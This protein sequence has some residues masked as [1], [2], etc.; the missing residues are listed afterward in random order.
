M[1]NSRYLPASRR[2]CVLVVAC[3]CWSFVF[4][5]PTSLAMQTRTLN[6]GYTRTLTEEE[7]AHIKG[8]AAIRQDPGDGGGGVGGNAAASPGPGY[9]W[10]G[11][12]GDVST[13][14]GNKL[15]A[16]PTV[17]WTARGGMT[18]DLTLYHN[19]ETPF[20]GSR[21]A[22]WSLIYD[23]NISADTS[24]NV[25]VAWG[26][27][28][29]YTFGKNVD[30]SYSPPPGIH[31]RL[32]ANGSASYDLITKSQMR[33]HFVPYGTQ[34]IFFLVSISD[35][36]G[37]T[38]TVNRASNGGTQSIT[39][40]TGRTATF[41]YNSNYYT[42][43][44][45]P[46]N[47]TV[48]FGFD[49][50][51]NMQTVTYPLLYGVSYTVVL[52]YDANHN[53]ISYK[54]RQGNLSHFTYN[55]DNSL[56]TE[57]TAI[58][59][60]TTFTY[61]YGYNGLRYG[62]NTFL[63]TVTDANGHA[64]TH[65]YDNSGRLSSVYDAL[66]NGVTYNYDSDNNVTWFLDARGQYW[67]KSYDTRGNVL[68]TTDPLSHQQ[69][70]T[71]NAHNRLLTAQAPSGRGIAVTYDA[72]D[73]PVKVQQKDTAGNV[74]ATTTY[75]VGN[76]GLVKDKYD[77]NSNH[78][79]Y[80]YDANGYLASVTTPLG[81]P[82]QWT[83][84]ALGFRTSRTDAMSRT[85]YYTP[86]TWERVVTTTYP[87][88]SQNTYG[89]DANGNLTAFAGYAASWTRT[90]DADNRMLAEYIGS[91]PIVSHTYDAAG[92]KGLLSSITDYDGRTI[93]YTYTARNEMST[94]SEASGT[95]SYAYDAAGSR[96]HYYAPNGLRTD[97]YYN[98]DNTRSG[99]YDWDGAG[100]IWQSYGYTYDADGRINTYSEGQSSNVQNSPNPTQTTY[101]YDGIGRLASENRTGNGPSSQTYAWD[102]ASN[103]LNING[104]NPLT[105]DADSEVK[106]VGG[107][108]VFGLTYNANG[109]R[110]G[111]T[112]NGQATTFTYDFDD[113]LTS[114]TTASGTIS[115]RYDAIGRQ[116]SKAI[117]G[118]FTG[119]YLDGNTIL[120]EKTNGANSAQ[121]TWG[122][123]LIRCN[124]E[125]PMEDG[126]GNVR[127]TTDAAKTITS[128]NAP[129]AF[130]ASSVTTNTASAFSWN[131]KSG[132]R[133]DGVSP[134]GLSSGY[135]FQ[136]VGDRYYDPTL[137]CFL[138]RDT[139]LGQLPYTYCGGDPVNFNDPTGHKTKKHPTDP[140]I[141][142]G[143]AGGGTSGGGVG[144][145]A[146]SDGGG[147]A[148]ATTIETG[149]GTV[150]VSSDGSSVS[151]TYNS[152][153]GQVT[154]TIGANGS[155]T[156][157]GTASQS[158]TFGNGFSVIGGENTSTAGRSSANVGLQ[159]TQ[160]GFSA[161]LNADTFGNTTF[162]L[163]FKG[164]W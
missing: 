84:D 164:S 51:G 83:Y 145:G 149:S 99:Y 4:F 159:Y 95:A 151:I 41:G 49:S 70:Y 34:G 33:W 90:Y 150:T 58:G 153:N 39:D 101:G 14:T 32:I 31:D 19:S 21:G 10:I 11:T 17:G 13:A 69:I 129:N 125:Y 53:I 66:R 91:T 120:I 52:G 23:S 37:N 5:A 121:Y 64:I 68:T 140:G 100:N 48:S 85:T 147:N 9:P 28:A 55:S 50:A 44:T 27:G 137:M 133:Q 114:I 2:L 106:T 119:Y 157:T 111:E 146:G 74:Q 63:T 108:N 87:D 127:F 136:K 79:A 158:S 72:A 46:L 104:V 73:N 86:D 128:S 18:V 22:K 142:G 77:P 61:G 118:T 105:Y 156:A 8:A 102:A 6:S 62:G 122:D 143:G 148:G 45:D 20:N 36:N 117:N 43:I 47:H 35:E 38:I 29:R 135:A 54:D 30:G 80:A 107:Y 94:V 132:Y 92:Q 155:V 15:T 130:G 113:R 126:R 103:C 163:G 110:T 76:Y 26:N 42:S 40:P 112:I 65:S 71:Y 97:E 139:E 138:T 134:T 109:D 93:S 67:Y 144:G 162:S 161:A 115:Y 116:V 123:G 152:G 81:H 131:A 141:P 12:V 25:K 96:T 89:Y 75:T 56:A 16:V 3:F 1:N 124:G 82:T 88:N 24:G 78:T 60:T 57:Q 98:P 154:V 160:S 59:N 7:M